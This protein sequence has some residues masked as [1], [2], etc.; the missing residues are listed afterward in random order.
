MSHRPDMSDDAMR[1]YDAA[2]AFI[3]LAS[4]MAGEDH[5]DVRWRVEDFRIVVGY[6]E[7]GYGQREDDVIVF[8]NF[9]PC[10]RGRYGQPG[11]VSGFD[12]YRDDH[13]AIEGLPARLGD[14]FERHGISIEWADE[15]GECCDCGRAFRT[16]GD[17]YSWQPS[18][19]AG[20]DG[21]TC[22]DCTLEDPSSYLES[23]EGEDNKAITFDIDPEK[24]DYH[25]IP[26]RF[27]NGLYGGQS[28]RPDRIA[29]AL[30]EMDIDRFVFRIDSVGQFDMRFSV[31]VHEDDAEAYAD[32]GCFD[33]AAKA[34]AAR[35][36]GA[37]TDGPDPAAMLKQALV[38]VPLAPAGPGVSYTKVD[39]DNGTAET[40]KVSPEDFRA[41]N[42]P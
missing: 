20:E 7:P 29:A 35:L 38:S 41:G 39:L 40:Y 27:E 4:E 22:R 32:D 14:I 18:Y 37:D 36:E 1:E 30:H 5:R 3:D 26:L 15:W 23:L 6:A 19:V 9:N 16:S 42:L 28:A 8:G 24:H 31:Y 10:D 34:I 21:Y 33:Y 25:R 13:R 12:L 17:S 11:H 2:R